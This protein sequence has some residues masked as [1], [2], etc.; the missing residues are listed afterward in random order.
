M[1]PNELETRKKDDLK[2][3]CSTEQGRRFLWEVIGHCGVYHDIEGEGIAAYKQIGRRQVGLHLLAL[4]S[5]ATP[6]SIFAMM[7]EAQYREIQEKLSHDN[8]DYGTN[9]STYDAAINS[10]D[11]FIG[12]E[13]DSGAEL[14]TYAS[15]PLLF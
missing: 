1:T 8:P 15:G 3:V 4:I 7:R 14:P 2:W 6:E 13:S 12:A 5:N 11:A 9:A 10:L